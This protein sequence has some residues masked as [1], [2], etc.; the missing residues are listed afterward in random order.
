VGFGVGPGVGPGVGSSVDP[1]VG[2]VTSQMKQNSIILIFPLSICGAKYGAYA[3]KS[4]LTFLFK[5]KTNPV[6][7]MSLM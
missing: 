6:L 1:G 5:K 4:F 3:G 2:G 7:Y